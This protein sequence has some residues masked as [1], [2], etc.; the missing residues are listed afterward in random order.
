MANRGES[1][2]IP[3][4]D[5]TRPSSLAE[6]HWV[7]TWRQSSVAMSASLIAPHFSPSH[8]YVSHYQ[9]SLNLSLTDNSQSTSL[10]INLEM[11]L[12]CKKKTIKFRNEGNNGA[13]K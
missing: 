5:Q 8:P 2:F 12:K 7:P 3:A 13:T 10:E 1:Y 11:K 9:S 6:P 4:G